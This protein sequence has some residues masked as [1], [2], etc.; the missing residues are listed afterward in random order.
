M[1]HVFVK[2]KFRGKGEVVYDEILVD[3]G[4]TFTVLPLEV[5]DKLI[6]TPFTVE[7]KLGNGEKVVAKVYVAEAEIEG[8]RGPVRIVAFKGAIPVI[9]VDTLET[10]GLRVNPVTGKLEKTEYYML[11]V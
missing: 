3:T 10:L 8:R 11:Y 7:L 5:A 9:G 1:G 4:A 6:E 2:A